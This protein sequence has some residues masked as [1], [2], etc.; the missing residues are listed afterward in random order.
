LGG[1]KGGTHLEIC[2][3][4]VLLLLR[5]PQARQWRLQRAEEG[6]SAR[7]APE[8]VRELGGD[9]E[10]Q[11]RHVA[12]AALALKRRRRFQFFD[13][14]VVLGIRHEAGA[15]GGAFEGERAGRE[16]LTLQQSVHAPAAHFAIQCLLNL[17]VVVTFAWWRCGCAGARGA[18][19]RLEKP[20]IDA[21]RRRAAVRHR[22]HR[23]RHVAA[24]QHE[25]LHFHGSTPSGVDVLALFP[26]SYD[27]VLTNSSVRFFCCCDW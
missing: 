3:I 1:G 19:L 17:Q 7:A 15:D 16:R 13:Q 12:N 27:Q 24:L 5:V 20:A 9:A 21:R 22:E 25:A 23:Q 14:L 11:E 10:R 2:A 26:Q 4:R 18:H 6:D 8:G